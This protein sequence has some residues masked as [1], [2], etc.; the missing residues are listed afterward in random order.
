MNARVSIPAATHASD[1]AFLRQLKIANR[2][3]LKAML[4]VFEQ[5]APNGDPLAWKRAAVE[6]RLGVERIS[7]EWLDGS[8]E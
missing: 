2:Q 7:Y 6:R 5:L 4:A 1:R 8:I 3:Q